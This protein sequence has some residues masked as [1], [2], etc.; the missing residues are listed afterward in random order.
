MLVEIAYEELTPVTDAERITAPVRVPSVTVVPAMPD[1]SVA[2]EEGASTTPPPP[3]T[4]KV[5]T[6]PVTA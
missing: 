3:E 1:A 5:T 2:A 6:A 4:T